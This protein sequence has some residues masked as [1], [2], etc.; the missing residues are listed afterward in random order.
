MVQ[1][2]LSFGYFNL[3]EQWTNRGVKIVFDEA[4]STA[5]GHETLAYGQHLTIFS[6]ILNYRGIITTE[7][8]RY[9][10]TFFEII[11]FRFYQNGVPMLIQLD[12]SLF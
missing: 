8:P 1:G 11:Q 5:I 9:M 7:V 2:D 12:L 6:K 4:V 10:L 3:I